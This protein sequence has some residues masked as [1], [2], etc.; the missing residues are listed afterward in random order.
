MF[1]QE[2]YCRLF[3]L[4]PPTSGF[5]VVVIFFFFFN[6]TLSSVGHCNSSAPSLGTGDF[7]EESN[8]LVKGAWLLMSVAMF[9]E[10][11]MDRSARHRDRTAQPLSR[12]L[13]EETGPSV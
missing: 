4:F 13:A 12:S 9:E 11:N 1:W 2:R 5:F 3:S 6:T 10:Q 8:L 7:P